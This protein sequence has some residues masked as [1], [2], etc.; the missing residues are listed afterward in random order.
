MEHVFRILTPGLGNVGEMGIQMKICGITQYLIYFVMNIYTRI[1]LL[2][3]KLLVTWR[4]YR[5]VVVCDITKDYIAM[6]T[7]KTEAHRR[8]L[9]WIHFGE[10]PAA[11]LCE[12]SRVM[13]TQ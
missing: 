1:S 2:L 9:V 8:L 11:C 10:E 13:A 3:L 4:S 6:K 7:D 12:L 5:D